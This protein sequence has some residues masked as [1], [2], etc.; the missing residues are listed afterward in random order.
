VAGAMEA[1]LNDIP[2]LAFSLDVPTSGIWHFAL[3]SELAIPI[4]EE[5]LEKPLPPWTALNVNFPNI[6]QKDI[7]GLR[8]AKHGFSGF[9]EYYIEEK[10]EGARRKFRLE[11]EMIFRDADRTY[12]AASLRDGYITVTPLGTCWQD[13]NAWKIVEQW[14][15]F[16]S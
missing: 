7:K 2:A 14:K 1:C 5:A 12:D 8:M 3:A 11:G 9:K 16:K 15:V 4:I 6:P 13:N 10:S